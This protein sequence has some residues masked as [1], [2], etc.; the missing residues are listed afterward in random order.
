MPP[1]GRPCNLTR[2]VAGK[3]MTDPIHDLAA[4]VANARSAEMA[5]AHGAAKTF[6]LDTLGVGIVGSNGPKAS[7]LVTAM[8]TMGTG[9]DARVWSTGEWLPAA[10]AAMCNAY[11][12][13]CQEFDCVHEAAVAHVMTIVL[14][15][16]LAIA[17]RDGGVSGQ[18][19]IES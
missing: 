13:H 9:R 4:H 17:E 16:A 1:D 5:P 8:G 12:A 3:L 2:Q 15:A 6:I 10:A 19:L 11:Q 14:P 7:D 18:D